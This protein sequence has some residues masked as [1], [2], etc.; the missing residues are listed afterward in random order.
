MTF[1]N[2]INIV[3]LDGKYL[4]S[5]GNLYEDF[6]LT[7]RAWFKNEYLENKVETIITTIHTDYTTKESTIA[8]VSFIYSKDGSE[9]LGAAVL[10]IL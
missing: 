4:F 10:D 1:V 5:K 9:V 8:M 7:E 2:T 6:E 3:S